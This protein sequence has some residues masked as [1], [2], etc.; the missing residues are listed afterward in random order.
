MDAK[1]GGL[2]R[3][4]YT[5]IWDR[6]QND[7]V[8][9]ESL[10]VHGW[11]DEWVKYLDYI[12]EIDI[13]HNAPHR[14]RLRYE[15][16]VHMRG[17]DS[18]KQAGPLCQRP[19]YKSSANPLVSLQWA[20]GEEVP[21]IAIQERTRQDNTLDP[22][23]QQHLQWLSFNWPTYFSSSSSSISKDNSTWWSSSSWDHKWQDWHSGMWQTIGEADLSHSSHTISDNI[24]MW[25]NRH[26][27]ADWVCFKTQTLLVILRT[28]NQPQEE[29]CIFFGSR[30]FVLVSW[31]CKKQTDVSHSSTESEIISLQQMS[32]PNTQAFRKMVQLFIPKPR[33]RKSKEDRR[34]IN[35]VMWIMYP[36]THILLK[37][38]LSCTY[39][40][41]TKPWSKWELK[42]EVRRWD[43]C[44]EPTELRLIGCSTETIFEPKV[45]IKYVDTK[46]Q[47]ADILTRGVFRVTS[48]ITFSV[49]STWWVSRCSLADTSAFFFLIR[50]EKQS[51][52]SKRGQ[53]ATSSEGSPMAKPRPTIPAKAKSVN[54]VLRSPWSAKEHPP[55]DVGHLVNPGNDD[56]GQ[57]DNTSR[58]RLVRITQNPETESSQ[59]RRQEKAHSSDS[60]KLFDLEESSNST[61]TWRRVPAA[62]PR[63]K[64]QNMK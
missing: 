53:E 27:S 34:L 46:N 19:D 15:S 58:R 38:S 23:V 21:H 45:Q 36:P 10:L 33:P 30:T 7:E 40:K 57:G 29:C 16:T 9:R 8:F 47:P 63:T 25:E 12:S 43:T 32:N 59:A 62:T 52:M 24:V 20:Q 54:L 64:F 3:D 61:G 51:A 37:M 17:V 6:W 39:L 28:R 4:K 42:D 44:Q 11:T 48:G 49:C 22:A 35:W 26:S 2:K 41:T 56:E 60:W 55:H 50:S 13:C 1:R 5:S 14:Q 31:M 18:N